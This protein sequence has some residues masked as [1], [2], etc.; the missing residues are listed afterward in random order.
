MQ[1]LLQNALIFM[2]KPES[3]FSVIFLIILI[4]CF[5]YGIILKNNCLKYLLNFSDNAAQEYKNVKTHYLPDVFVAL[6]QKVL[7]VKESKISDLQ[8]VFV[9]VGILGTFIGLGIAIKGAAEL[10]NNE[11][12]DISKL[13]F[14]KCIPSI[15]SILHYFS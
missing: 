6:H 1:N 10:L 9:S 5:L 15:Y 4:S 14:T 12:I 11:N 3:T 2:F 7:S 8:N 13:Y